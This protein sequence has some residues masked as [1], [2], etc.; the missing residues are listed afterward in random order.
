[1]CVCV[2]THHVFV[3]NTLEELLDGLVNLLWLDVKVFEFRLELL[4]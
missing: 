3:L 4:R 1:M 2:F